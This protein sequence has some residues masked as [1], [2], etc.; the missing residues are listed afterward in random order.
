MAPLQRIEVAPQRRFSASS[1]ILEIKGTEA[2]C[3]TI[4]LDFYL[5][6][7]DPKIAWE[8]PIRIASQAAMRIEM[9]IA[10]L[11]SNSS[12]CG[13]GLRGALPGGSR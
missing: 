10:D 5:E 12:G 3:F 4:L 6:F 2:I 9:S 11:L 8:G 13:N 7:G 1:Y